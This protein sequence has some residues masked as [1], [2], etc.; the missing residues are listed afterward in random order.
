MGAGLA[1]GAR[2]RLPT[3]DILRLVAALSV[4]LFHYLF[5]GAAGEP[6]FLETRFP[7]IEGAAIYGYL[8]VNL[9]FLIS[10]FVIAW[11]AEGR[12]WYDFAIARVVR[13]VPGYFV[14]V[15]LTFL[16]LAAV[17]SPL[18]STSLGQY[19]A[20]LSFFAPVF[21]HSFMDGVYW[22]I[23]LELIFYGWITLALIT[24]AYTR[25]KLELV[26]GWLALTCVNEFAMESGAL[27]ILFLT[28]FAPWFASGM[29][30]HHLAT[31]GRSTETLLLLFA[32]FAIG[33][34][35]M[36]VAQ[37]WMAAHYGVAVPVAGLI[38]ANVTMFCLMFGALRFPSLVPPSEFVF[39]AGALTYPLYLLH[40]NI[41]YLAIDALAPMVGRWPAAAATTGVM[42]IGAFGVW[43][44]AESP[45]QRALKLLASRL[46]TAFHGARAHG[47]AGKAI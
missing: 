2:T 18:F 39:A 44:Y 42:L 16:V 32:A 45:M 27:R 7:E 5:R 12:T 33:C 30:M 37:D 29:L 26:V 41:G 46:V 9:F 13:L 22:S 14:C 20:N 19:V 23:M 43:R 38:A 4:V 11:S 8:G 17:A 6:A 24:G 3:L 34:A 15:T 21:G 36:Q 47:L 40:Q 10:G 1:C 31:R 28:E 35:T 25:L